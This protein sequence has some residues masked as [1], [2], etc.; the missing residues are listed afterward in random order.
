M[1]PTVSKTPTHLM[2][3]YYDTQIPGDE[4]ITYL[5]EKPLL[6]ELALRFPRE[7][8]EVQ[9]ASAAC[10]LLISGKMSQRLEP[11]NTDI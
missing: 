3:G 7:V 4:L 10:N 9:G 6:L 11:C 5:I 2:A 1:E 8:E